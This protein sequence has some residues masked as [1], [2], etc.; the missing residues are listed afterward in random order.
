MIPSHTRLMTMPGVAGSSFDAVDARLRESITARS[1][2]VLASDPRR[3]GD[4]P[5]ALVARFGV[6]EFNVT[7]ALLDGM[8]QVATDKGIAWDFLLRVDAKDPASSDREKLA[9]LAELALQLAWIEVEQSRDPL[10]L[11]NVDVLARYGLLGRVET[12]L[13][14]ATARPAARWILVPFHSSQSAPKFDDQP[15][16]LPPGGWL[17]LPGQLF[18][19]QAAG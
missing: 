14:L 9:E 3:I 11:T 17:P 4:A 18:E 16:P 19:E 12:L 1:V 7:S 2:V 6:T 13:D 15:V 8:R 10:L 5:A